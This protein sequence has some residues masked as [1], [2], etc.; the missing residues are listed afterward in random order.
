MIKAIIFDCW[1]TLFGHQLNKPHPFSIFAKRLGKSLQDYE[2]LKIFEK[3][4][5]LEKYYKLEVP[6]KALLEE[7]N[8]EHSEKLI[9]ELKEILEEAFHSQK[10]FPETLK[11]LNELKKN[12][13]LGLISNTFYQSFE[14]LEQRSKVQEIFDIILK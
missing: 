8:I 1:G 10:P 11:V 13:K 5:M 2:F 3:H 4:F 9:N 14:G 7:S 12:Y 6:I